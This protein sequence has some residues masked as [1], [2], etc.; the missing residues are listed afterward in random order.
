MSKQHAS[1]MKLADEYAD[2]CFDQG[3]YGR[4]KDPAP[5]A[6]RDAL[7][8]GIRRLH[9]ANAELVDVM[10][11]LLA[12]GEFT[13]YP[14]TRQADAVKAARAALSKHKEQA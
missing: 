1:L 7:D 4:R 13:D 8:A 14:G 10:S 2:A 11:D 6:K 3:L 5:E 9:A 12:E